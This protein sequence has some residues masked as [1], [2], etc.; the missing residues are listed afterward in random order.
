M[1]CPKC[2]HWTLSVINDHRGEKRL[3]KL[4]TLRLRVALCSP[5]GCNKI[6]S[7]SS[8]SIHRNS[9]DSGH[10]RP[11]GSFVAFSRK[12]IWFQGSSCLVSPP[13]NPCVKLQGLCR[14]SIIFAG[15][16]EDTL[17]FRVL[18]HAWISKTLGFSLSLPLQ[19]PY[20][21]VCCVHL[22][23]F[24][25]EYKPLIIHPSLLYHSLLSP[26]YLSPQPLSANSPQQI[27]EYANL[28][29]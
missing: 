2:V 14:T 27:W 22:G 15:M 6:E 17:Q 1:W 7:M 24:T 11:W 5:A 4:R 25:I 8:T 12:H 13:L 26:L 29:L 28:S 21:Q 18:W 23:V 19:H 20:L 3:L 9:R 16:K 10:N